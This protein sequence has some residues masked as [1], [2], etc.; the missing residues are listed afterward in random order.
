MKLGSKEIKEGAK[1]L[2]ELADLIN[3]HNMKTPSLLMILTG[4][5]FAIIPRRMLLQLSIHDEW[6]TPFLSSDPHIC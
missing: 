4:G 1:H 3:E 6:H 5:E 2:L